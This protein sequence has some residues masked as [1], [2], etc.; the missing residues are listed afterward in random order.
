[1]FRNDV[2]LM[3]KSLKDLRENRK[4]SIKELSYILG[5]PASTLSAYER[6]TKYPNAEDL[7]KLAYHYRMDLEEMKDLINNQNNDKPTT[8]TIT[9]IKMT[10]NT[11]VYTHTESM[12]LYKSRENDKEYLLVYMCDKTGRYDLNVRVIRWLD[13]KCIYPVDAMNEY[14]VNLSSSASKLSSQTVDAK[15]DERI[16]VNATIDTSALDDDDPSYV[17]RM[18]DELYELN[19]KIDKIRL[20]D[21]DVLDETETNLLT[22]QFNLMIKYADILVQRIRYAKNKK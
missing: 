22:N 10:D 21:K 4:T 3:S 15:Q 13:V 17:K 19:E 12:E 8:F 5:I 11:V 6:G 18:V 16:V 2:M 14:D 20:M 1:M 7:Q 9:A